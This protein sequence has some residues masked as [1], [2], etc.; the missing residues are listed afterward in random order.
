MPYDVMSTD[1][2][3]PSIPSSAAALN[4]KVDS[5][6]DSRYQETLS[7]AG[8]INSNSNSAQDKYVRLPLSDMGSVYSQPFTDPYSANN[9]QVMAT[10]GSKSSS[11]N[12][13]FGKTATGFSF[14]GG[15]DADD[16]SI[17]SQDDLLRS[18]TCRL[19]LV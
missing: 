16:L 15:M 14:G 10:N 9:S 2:S 4:K 7:Q 6:Y 5:R 1:P 17:R 19:S 11:G 12:N 8:S 3:L 13:R 18:V